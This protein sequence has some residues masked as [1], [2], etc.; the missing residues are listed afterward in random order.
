[1]AYC[2]RHGWDACRAHAAAEQQASHLQQAVAALQH[3]LH[4]DKLK[5]DRIMTALAAQ[6]PQD[7]DEQLQQQQQQ[8]AEEED[9]QQDRRTRLQGKCTSDKGVQ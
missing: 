4:A 8:Q 5:Y 6:S 3:T 9:V 7:S 2:E 1:M